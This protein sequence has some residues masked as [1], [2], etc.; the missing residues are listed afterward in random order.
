MIELNNAQWHT[1]LFLWSV[2]VWGHFKGNPNEIERFR[3]GTNVCHYIRTIFVA[4]PFAFASVG[5]FIWWAVYV[6][7]ISPVGDLGWLNYFGGLA[8]FSAVAGLSMY[9]RW[10]YRGYKQGRRPRRPKPEHGRLV[11]VFD[12]IYEFILAQ[13]RK[14]CP[15]ITIG[16]AGHD[17]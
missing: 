17:A 9:C 8:V 15:L 3:H 14:V 4:A 12:L 11:S 13:K 7:I 1:R 10:F 16:G 6:L 2:D 5:L